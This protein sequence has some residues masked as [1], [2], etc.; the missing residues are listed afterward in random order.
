[1]GDLSDLQRGQIIGVRMTGATV[2][3][4]AELLGISRDTVSKVVTAYEKEGTSSVKHKSGRSFSLSE[5][6]RITLNRIVRKDHK[7][8]ASKITARIVKK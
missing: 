5:R 4:T 2:T 3:E 8:T 1:M 7:T 6:D